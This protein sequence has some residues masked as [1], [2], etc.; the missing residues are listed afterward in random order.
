MTVLDFVLAFIVW[1]SSGVISYLICKN[2]GTEEK[3]LNIWPH[4]FAGC[5]GLLIVVVGAISL[6]LI[7]IFH[8]IKRVKYQEEPVVM[9]FLDEYIEVAHTMPEPIDNRFDILD[10]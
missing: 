6:F 5:Y 3:H 8:K 4:L 10:L 2:L 9:E 7:Y 1:I